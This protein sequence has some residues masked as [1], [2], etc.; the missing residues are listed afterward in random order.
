MIF[1]GHLKRIRPLAEINL[2]PSTCPNITTCFCTQSDS[3]FSAS[4]FYSKKKN[5]LLNGIK[6]KHQKQQHTL[7]T[8]FHKRALVTR[9]T[10]YWTCQ[11]YFWSLERNPSQREQPTL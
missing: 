3:T 5:Y 10:T 2:A 9:K 8:E 6:I 4:H 7:E 1:F 11:A